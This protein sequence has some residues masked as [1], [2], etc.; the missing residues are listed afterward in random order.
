M[1]KLLVLFL[2]A[3]VTVGVVG[4]ASAVDYARNLNSGEY[5]TPPV[6]SGDTVYVLATGTV[7]N[8]ATLFQINPST[9]VSAYLTGTYN[10]KAAAGASAYTGPVLYQASGDS[11]VTLVMQVVQTPATIG[12][13]AG[14]NAAQWEL[15]GTS[16]YAF[17]FSPTNGVGVTHFNNAA[18][19]L[20]HMS[21]GIT[22][23]YTQNDAGL[24]AG[25]SSWSSHLLV[26]ADTTT[27]GT[28]VFGTSG[29]SAYAGASIWSI[30]LGTVS[31]G[32]RLNSNAFNGNSA[33]TRGV[34]GFSTPLLISGNSLFAIGDYRYT[35]AASGVSLLMFDK[36]K[37]QAGPNKAVELVGAQQTP[38]ITPFPTPAISGNSIFVV[39]GVGGLTAYSISSTNLLPQA[40]NAL[41]FVQLGNTVTTAVSASPVCDTQFLAV[42]VNHLGTAVAGI[43]VFRIDNKAIRSTSGTSWWYEWTAGTTIA[44][45]PV[46]SNGNLYVAVNS[47]N[48]GS[49]LH[50]FVMNR[51]AQGHIQA[52]DQSWTVD[53]NGAAFGFIE[54][55]GLILANGRLIAL[56]NHGGAKRIYSIDVTN[57]ALGYSYWRQFKFDAARSGNNT[58]SPDVVPAVEDDDDTCF[59]S[60]LK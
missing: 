10:G 18:I 15:G 2:A 32:A 31:G 37:L 42:A 1:K 21:G 53:A 50:R 6:A 38:G 13:T 24:F 44:A 22:A 11:G 5:I 56:S 12:S 60:T 27:G 35:A 58:R 17:Y 4:T 8:G 9:G 52:P 20:G 25:V 36:R 26:D 19:S 55:N 34:S 41:D 46:I 57:S 29:V 16:V 39:D 49:T 7:G 43:T 45:T 23:F 40:R 59:I 54:T 51:A 33:A 3:F 30:G 14:Q 47:R 28:S 48:N